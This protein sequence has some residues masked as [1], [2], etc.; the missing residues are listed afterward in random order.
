MMDEAMIEQ[1]VRK[2]LESEFLALEADAK[3]GI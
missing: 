1:R 3:R 2:R